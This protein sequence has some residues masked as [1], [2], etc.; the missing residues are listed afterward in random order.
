MRRSTSATTSSWLRRKN[1][2]WLVRIMLSTLLPVALSTTVDLSM[3]GVA[4][5]G[6]AGLLGREARAAR[7][8]ARSQRAA[9]TARSVAVRG[10]RRRDEVLALALGHKAA[11]QICAWSPGQLFDASRLQTTDEDRS[12]VHSRGFAQRY[13]RLSRNI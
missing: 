5:A 8:A 10:T 11:V 1:V 7:R 12:G 6:N 13:P 2:P 9:L 4:C 3:C